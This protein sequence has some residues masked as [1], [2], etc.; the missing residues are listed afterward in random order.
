MV[1]ILFNNLSGLRNIIIFIVLIISSGCATN[2]INQEEQ[3]DA[4]KLEEAEKQA[5]QLYRNNSYDDALVKY[6]TIIN[7]DPV[8]ENAYVRIGSIHDYMKSYTLAAKAYSKA[9]EINNENITAREGLGIVLLRQGKHDVAQEI[10][11]QL[12]KE[13]PERWKANN[14]LGVIYDMD[15]NHSMAI[16]SYNQ[17][18]QFRDN[19]PEILNNMGY[20]YYLQGDGGWDIA[21]DYFVKAIRIDNNFDKAWSNLGLLYA[22]KYNYKKSLTAFSHF[23]EL[24]E[25]NNQVGYLS[26]LAGD[27]DTSELYFKKAIVVAPFYYEAAH[28]NLSRLKIMKSSL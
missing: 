1:N 27:Y 6:V 7:L 15:K 25:A 2:K 28:Q 9:L 14:T 13:H 11:E 21:E 10:L 8:N 12:V 17:A 22:R 19:D 20:S 16:A 26:M 3:A 18:L 24:H 23:M 4:K 5:E